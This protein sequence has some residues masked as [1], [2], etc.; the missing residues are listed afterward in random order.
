MQGLK[1]RI[2]YLTAYEAIAIA[3]SATAMALVYGVAPTDAGL[4]SII[5]SAIA[6]SWN[7]LYNTGFEW[8]ES[9]QTRRGRG[10]GRRVLHAVGFEF[11]L[12]IVLVPLLA[13]WLGISLI[14]AFVLDLGLIMFFLV[15]TFVFNLVFDRLFGLP[16]SAA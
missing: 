14:E 1:R 15:Y 7:F 9:R 6:M 3:L 8:W 2:V 13:L 5:A 16:T 10:I 4:L 11:G 12:V